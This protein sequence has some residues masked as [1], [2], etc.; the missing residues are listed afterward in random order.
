MNDKSIAYVIKT[1]PS[2]VDWNMCLTKILQIL[3]AMN[4]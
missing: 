3:S 1:L 2:I 4:F